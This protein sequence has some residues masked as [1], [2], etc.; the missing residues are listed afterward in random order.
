M[1]S[2][3]VLKLHIFNF[4]RSHRYET[5]KIV[6][7]KVKYLKSIAVRCLHGA[8]DGIEIEWLAENW[9]TFVLWVCFI[10]IDPF[11]FHVQTINDENKKSIY[12][13]RSFLTIIFVFYCVILFSKIYCV[14]L[15]LLWLKKHEMTKLF[16]W[17]K[18]CGIFMYLELL[19]CVSSWCKWLYFFSFIFIS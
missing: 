10:I 3:K 8:L 18:N 16:Q 4:I 14:I 11:V 19:L 9:S 17:T 1:I 2:F 15:Y 7:R 13:D 12:F 6:I 5:W